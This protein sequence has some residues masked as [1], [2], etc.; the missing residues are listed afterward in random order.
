MIPKK[1][2][3]VVNGLELIELQR[4]ARHLALEEFGME[5][6]LKI[7]NKSVAV[8]GAGGLG[9]PVLLYLAAA[10]VG[11][12]GIIE[13]DVI[14]LSNLQRQVLFATEQIG[15]LKAEA[16]AGRIQQL[17]PHVQTT[18][19]AKR[20][21]STNALSILEPFDL[22]IDATDNFPTRYLVNDAC[23]LLEKPLVYGSIHRF[24]GQ[25]SVFNYRRSDGSRGP[26]YRDL[27][28]TPPPPAQVPNCAEAGVLGVLPGIIGSMQASEALQILSERGPALDGK[29][30]IFDALDF[31]T[32]TMKIPKNPDIQIEHLIDY[33]V[34]CG[35]IQSQPIMQ[36]VKEITAQE[37]KALQDGKTDLQLIDV[38]EAYERE[39]GHIGGE[40]IPMG[41]I[42]NQINTIER[43]KQVVVYCRSGKRSAD[44]IR[45]LQEQH[46]FG[47]LLNLAGGIL[48]WSDEIDP[49]I[50]KY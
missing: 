48:A 3:L 20:L 6:Q 22:V 41:T 4:Y 39:I 50:P 33:D 19:F 42:P 30:F 15:Q 37:L 31:R 18:V 11:Q 17:N 34:F 46:Q 35:N 23:C 2:I 32:Q 8:V 29:L 14:E 5:G 13:Q 47:N 28:P 12:I 24:E 45:Y 38:R 26:N 9:S 49:S 36:H 44:I 27:F 7:R 21:D 1:G 10:G 40:H 16:A 43:D 25:V